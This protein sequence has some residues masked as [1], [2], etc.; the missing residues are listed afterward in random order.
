MEM[1]KQWADQKEKKKKDVTKG[2]ASNYGYY[3]YYYGEGEDQ[4]R[5]SALLR[6]PVASQ[7][8]ARVSTTATLSSKL[9]N[10]PNNAQ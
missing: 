4:G 6:L 3:Y 2:H 1:L 8:H 5:H 10:R 7:K 9:S